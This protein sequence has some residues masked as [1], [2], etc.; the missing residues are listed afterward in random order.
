LGVAGADVA[1]LFDDAMTVLWADLGPYMNKLLRTLHSAKGNKGL[2]ARVGTKVHTRAQLSAA[3]NKFMG[4]IAESKGYRV[5]SEVE[6]DLKTGKL[7]GKTG[8]RRAGKVYIDKL[9][10]KKGKSITNKSLRELVR[11]EGALAYDIKT[12]KSLRLS[13]PQKEML[14]RW[15]GKDK[16]IRISK[17]AKPK[18][19]RQAGARIMKRL[20]SK[21]GA[22][23]KIGGKI[24]GVFKILFLMWCIQEASEELQHTEKALKAGELTKAGKHLARTGD[25]FLGLEATWDTAYPLGT[26]IRGMKLKATYDS[27]GMKELGDDIPGDPTLGQ[28][29]DKEIRSIESTYSAYNKML[30]AKQA[31]EKGTKGLMRQGKGALDKAKD[32]WKKWKF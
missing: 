5:L 16:L 15:K 26:E 3:I 20:G 2:A 27:I 32:A 23:K 14:K 12:G 7:T 25:A 29:W 24:G 21:R 18:G 8:G 10:V 28:F 13:Q 1:Q 17:R 19:V 30:Q 9:W 4:I 11:K 31:A 6:V 22:F